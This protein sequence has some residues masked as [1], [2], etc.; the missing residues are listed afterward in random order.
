MDWEEGVGWEEG[1][2]DIDEGDEGFTFS[3]LLF[4]PNKLKDRLAGRA[5]GAAEEEEE[6]EPPAPAPGSLPNSDSSRSTSLG[7]AP[8]PLGRWGRVMLMRFPPDVTTDWS[9]VRACACASKNEVSLSSSSAFIRVRSSESSKAGGSPGTVAAPDSSMRASAT[10]CEKLGNA[11][12]ES[13][14]DVQDGAP[15]PRG[16][17]GRARAAFDEA[18]IVLKLQRPS[19]SFCS[20]RP[21][22]PAGS[23][24]S[25]RRWPPRR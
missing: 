4:F 2:L 17:A 13:S 16:S 23:C 19:S 24:S 12:P 25:A 20:L 18:A 21:E 6:A 1:V 9:S 3:S 5:G 8:N 7:G 10:I 14:G 15:P 22:F 11:A